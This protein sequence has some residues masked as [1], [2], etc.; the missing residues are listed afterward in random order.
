[1]TYMA[2]PYLLVFTLLIAGI[3]RAGQV[4]IVVVVVYITLV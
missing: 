2:F 4:I 1:M 3:S